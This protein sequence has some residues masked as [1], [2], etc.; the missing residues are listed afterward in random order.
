MKKTIVTAAA[1]MTA[2]IFLTACG[3]SH[4]GGRDTATMETAV[5]QNMSAQV[6]R[7]AEQLELDVLAEQLDT[8]YHEVINYFVVQFNPEVRTIELVFSSTECGFGDEED[9]YIFCP[10]TEV[11]SEKIFDWSDAPAKNRELV[12]SLT[13]DQREE[14]EEDFS[15]VFFGSCFDRFENLGDTFKISIG[16]D[17][18]IQT[19]KKW[20]YEYADIIQQFVFPEKFI[21]EHVCAYPLEDL[22]YYHDEFF[23]NEEQSGMF[24]A[25]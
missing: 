20:D 15:E 3:G 18:R 11:F 13:L 14:I 22:E 21:G 10:T 12:S 7:L 1:A 6:D 5:E 24:T 19:S 16:E 17:G 9:E 25:K 23:E 8:E 4:G 2:M